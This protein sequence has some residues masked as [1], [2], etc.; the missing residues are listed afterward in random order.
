MVWNIL[1]QNCV[2]KVQRVQ[3]SFHSVIM[4]NHQYLW[5]LKKQTCY[6]DIRYPRNWITFGFQSCW[7]AKFQSF[8]IKRYVFIS[9]LAHTKLQLSEVCTGRK[10]CASKT[11]TKFIKCSHQTIKIFNFHKNWTKK[12]VNI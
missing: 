7:N 11:H 8:G 2:L 12:Q 9:S 10:K 3:N 4:L 1:N 5:I 6:F